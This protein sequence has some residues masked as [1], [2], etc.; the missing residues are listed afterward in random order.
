MPEDRTE[1]R[2]GRSRLELSCLAHLWHVALSLFLE[3]TPSSP[4]PQAEARRQAEKPHC[5]LGWVVLTHLST[6]GH[7]ESQQGQQ[8]LEFHSLIKSK[9][10]LLFVED[11]P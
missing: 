7:L 6:Q 5:T 1:R 4:P 3:H 9:A 10:A 8:C 11:F 2:L